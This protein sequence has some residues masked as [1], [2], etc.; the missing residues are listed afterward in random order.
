MAVKYGHINCCYINMF[1][2]GDYN[3]FTRSKDFFISQIKGLY[4][5]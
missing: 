1:V 3:Y 5:C 4:G 2:I